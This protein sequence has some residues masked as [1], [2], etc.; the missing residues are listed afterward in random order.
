MPFFGGAHNFSVR[1]AKMNDI[2]GD[3]TEN[4]TTTEPKNSDSNNVYI[5]STVRKGNT[6]T[7][8]TTI[9]GYPHQPS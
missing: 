9:G 7:N 8:T 5:A 6:K 1:D 3:Y 4:K 2:G